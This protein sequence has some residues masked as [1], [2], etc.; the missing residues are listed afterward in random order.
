M[1]KSCFVWLAIYAVL[2][3]AIGMFV[4]RRLPER[5][6]VAGVALGAGFA[7]WL[8]LSYLVYI[9]RKLAEGRMVQTMDEGAPPVDGDKIAVV[10]PIEPSG[11]TLLSPI[12]RT[13]CVAYKYEIVHRS[14]KH[15]AVPLYD[16]Y[17]I[18]PS[19]VQSPRGSIHILA[20]PALEVQ[21][22][23]YLTDEARAN[24]EKYVAETTFREHSGFD[25]RG[26]WN[27]TMR[28]LKDADG[29]IRVDRHMTQS[30]KHID[31]AA[32]FVE[33]VVRP[34]DRVCVIGRYSSQHGGIVPDAEN[35]LEQ[36]R[37]TDASHTP[38]RLGGAI[39]Y[40]FGAVLTFAIGAAVIIG[41]C[42]AVP[43]AAGEQRNPQWQPSWQ[44][45]RL[46]RWIDR[47]LRP[48]LRKLK[49]LYPESVSVELERGVAQGRMRVAGRDQVLTHAAM[50]LDDRIAVVHIDDD[51]VVLTV[52]AHDRLTALRIGGQDIGPADL[53]EAQ[54][55]LQG[56]GEHDVIGR[57]VY[58]RDDPGAPAVRVAFH[59]N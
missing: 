55:E 28:D 3:V 46:E 47:D 10:G 23:T 36:V 16:G 30:T 32:M 59:A 33:W 42:A 37:L 39:G 9:P 57:L 49:L 27:E 13:P 21:R 56:K 41:F 50:S 2:A 45:I 34:G 11:A 6:V 12:T 14:Q 8:A 43:L 18:V 17:A 29:D 1:K 58:F 54:L 26:A 5:G 52:D 4:Y 53:P 38:S 19:F 20:N 44:E 15:S 48:R 7:F 22:N 25:V 51:A 31:D 35:P 24:A 40:A